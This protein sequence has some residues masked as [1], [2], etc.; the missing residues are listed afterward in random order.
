LCDDDGGSEIEQEVPGSDFLGL[1]QLRDDN[2][3][4]LIERAVL[5]EPDSALLVVAKE[6][7]SLF[8]LVPLDEVLLVKRAVGASFRNSWLRSRIRFQRQDRQ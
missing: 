6:V 5:V 2:R 1:R 8:G 4:M 3:F 7:V